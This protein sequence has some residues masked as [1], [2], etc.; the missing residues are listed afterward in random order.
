MPITLQLSTTTF[1]K[2]VSPPFSTANE[3][4]HNNNNT[5]RLYIKDKNSKLQFLID[6]GAEL[7]VIPK[8]KNVH[9]QPSLIKLLAANNTEI[10][11]YGKRLLSLDIG[12][13]RQFKWLFT[14]AD[15]SHP[16]IG[17]DFLQNFNILVDMKG[18]SL[19]DATTQLRQVCRITNSDSSV[20]TIHKTNGIFHE[21]LTQYI[22]LTDDSHA[23]SKKPSEVKHYIIIYKGAPGGAEGQTII[24]REIGDCEKR[25]RLHVGPRHLCTIEEPMG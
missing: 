22:D 1:G 2:L 5:R 9:L 25:V 8:P 10:N 4:G 19:V 17:A 13:R 14:V 24:T 21:L 7:S 20:I 11:T 15:V 12:L 18:K 23:L 16:I 3:E 6:T